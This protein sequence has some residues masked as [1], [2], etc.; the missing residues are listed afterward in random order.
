MPRQFPGPPQP[1]L[2]PRPAPQFQPPAAGRSQAKKKS[3]FRPWMVIVAIVLAA[4][5]AAGVVAMS[6]PDVAVQ[7]S[8]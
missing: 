5:V 6:G 7:H 2:Q 8:K 3:F 4:A 1:Q